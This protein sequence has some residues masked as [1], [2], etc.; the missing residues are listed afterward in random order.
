LQR[1]TGQALSLSLSLSLSYFFFSFS[2][3]V[4]RLLVLLVIVVVEKRTIITEAQGNAQLLE[5]AAWEWGYEWED[6]QCLVVLRGEGEKKA[7]KTVAEDDECG[8]TAPQGS[9]SRL[10]CLFTM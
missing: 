8:E 6:G 7:K 10:A 3:S 5:S 4:S 9:L 2:A 1:Q